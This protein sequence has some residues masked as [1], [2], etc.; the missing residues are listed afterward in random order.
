M[1]ITQRYLT[2]AAA[3]IM[4]LGD[5][6]SAQITSQPID[7]EIIGAA[8]FDPWSFTVRNYGGKCLDYSRSRN[9]LFSGAVFLN[10]CKLAHP[11]QVEEIT[12]NNRHEVILHA[13][14]RV[15][16]IRRPVGTL[17]EAP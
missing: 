17:F 10:D 9:Q 3:A 4:A 8:P 5:V 2:M 7:D 15:L 6:A 13:G 14:S 12:N 1:K 16:G 11:I